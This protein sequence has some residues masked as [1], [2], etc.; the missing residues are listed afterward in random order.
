MEEGGA[1]NLIY[2][3][4]AIAIAAAIPAVL[5]RLP[6]PGAVL[7]IVLGILIGPQV[8]GL[9]KPDFVLHFLA[10][11]GLGILFLMAGFE[12]SPVELRGRPIRNATLGWMISAAIALY[13]VFVLG[14]AGLARRRRS[15]RSPSARPRS[16]CCSRCS[17]MPGS[18]GHPTGPR[19][20]PS[21][22]WGKAR[23]CSSCRSFSPIRAGPGAQALVMVAFAACAVVAVAIASHASR[24]AFAAVLRANHGHLGAAADAARALPSHPP[25]H[26][27]GALRDRLR[28]RRLR[29]GRRRPR[30]RAR[31]RARGHGGAARRDRLGVPGAGLLREFRHEP[32]CRRPR[33]RSGPRSP[34]SRSMPCSCWSCAGRRRCFSTGAI[35]AP[36]RSAALALH[37]AT[38]LA[39]VVAIAGLAV[40]RGL[41][42][43]AQAASLVA[44][45]TVTVLVF[46]AIAA[47]VLPTVPAAK[48]NSRKGAPRARHVAPRHEAPRGRMSRGTLERDEEKWTPVFRPRPALESSKLITFMNLDQFRSKFIVI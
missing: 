1:T 37:S 11:F 41:M 3:G 5:P 42:P 32:R 22:P 13:A 30:R 21:A 33:R 14:V 47:R 16:A 43:S 12:M 10:D 40:G 36:T 39:L 20:S 46:P 24:G 34:W 18:W 27:L 28:A 9:A 15:P 38:Q 6:V 48:A 31:P 29:R 2:V 19:C 8:L 25:D 44:A 45:A 35:C 23:P 17:A 26:G 7:E 4:V